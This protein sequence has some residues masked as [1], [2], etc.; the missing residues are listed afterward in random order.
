MRWGGIPRSGGLVFIAFFVLAT[1]KMTLPYPYYY[2]PLMG[3]CTVATGVVAGILWM[4]RRLTGRVA[5]LLAVAASGAGTTMLYRDV[6]RDFKAVTPYESV[7][8]HVVGQHP[9]DAGREL[10]LPFQL[11][12]MLHYYHPNIKTVGYD[13]DFPLP[14][15]ADGIQSKDAAGIMFCEA[16]FCDG[17]ERQ[18]PGFAV[19]KTLLDR[20]GPNGQLFY[21]IELRKS[22][23]L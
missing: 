15:L 22:G 21:L 19:R 4:R 20:P 14:R 18:A 11:V 7:V 9:V 8:L 10:Y 2:A 6:L 12:P 13:F 1:M 17:L 23:S 3:A 5:L 16:A